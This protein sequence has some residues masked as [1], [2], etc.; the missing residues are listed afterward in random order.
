MRNLIGFSRSGDQVKR[1]EWPFIQKGFNCCNGRE[2]EFIVPANA[3]QVRQRLLI[4]IALVNRLF[5]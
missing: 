5:D 4:E 3:P 2:I 1:A